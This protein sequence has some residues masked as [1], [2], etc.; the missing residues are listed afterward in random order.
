M[1][2]DCQP[3][4]EGNHKECVIVKCPCQHKKGVQRL[5]K[6]SLRKGEGYIFIGLAPQGVEQ[7]GMPR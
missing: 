4:I 3:C 6:W 1:L 7:T 2:S 5:S